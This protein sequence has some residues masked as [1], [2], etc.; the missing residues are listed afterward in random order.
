MVDINPAALS[1]PSIGLSTPSFSGKPGSVNVSGPS[2]ASASVPPTHSKPQKTSLVPPRIDLEPI[3]TTLK[4]AIGAE[5]WLVYKET[6]TNFLTGTFPQLVFT[7][8]LD[9]GLLTL[10]KTNIF[11]AAS[12]KPS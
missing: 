6:L 3:Y 4:A 8:Y 5:Q 7:K 9:R 11:Q 12:T 10:D 1:R 2:S